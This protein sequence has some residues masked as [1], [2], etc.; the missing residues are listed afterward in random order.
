MEIK[1]NS[2]FKVPSWERIQ[3]Q[4]RQA[5][6]LVPLAEKVCF[7]WKGFREI[8]YRIL[9]LKFVEKNSNTDTLY[10]CD[11][12][13]FREILYR[14]LFF[15]FVEKNSNTDT[16]FICDWKG[17]REILYRILFLKFVGKNSNTDTLYICDGYLGY[18]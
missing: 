8:L 5:S 9:F 3:Y 14:I 4:L 7:H 6:L 10:I 13:G 11:W 12:K 16:L 18:H 15:K 1:S 17:F 2:Y